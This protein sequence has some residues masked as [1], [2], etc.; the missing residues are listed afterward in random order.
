LSICCLTGRDIKYSLRSRER[1]EEEGGEL[2]FAF[3]N[4]EFCNHDVTVAALFDAKESLQR[5]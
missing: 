4:L 1:E 5:A 2:I 3:S